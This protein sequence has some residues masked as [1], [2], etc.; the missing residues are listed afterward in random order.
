MKVGDLVRLSS[1]GNKVKSNSRLIGR[2]D[3]GMIIKFNC[4]DTPSPDFPYQVDWF[5]LQGIDKMYHSRQDL[6]Y[7]R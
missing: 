2:N 1:Y 4:H 3:L 5:D 7:A 6:K